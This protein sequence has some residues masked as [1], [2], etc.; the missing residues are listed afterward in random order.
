V[1]LSY[2]ASL[3]LGISARPPWNSHGRYFQRT[4]PGSARDIG[5]GGRT[6]SLHGAMQAR[7]GSCEN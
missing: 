2:S 5:N 4:T 6:T 1:L 7:L 3:P